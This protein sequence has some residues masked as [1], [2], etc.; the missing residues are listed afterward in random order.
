MSL[1]V[2]CIPMNP[3]FPAQILL[4][5]DPDL[6]FQLPPGYPCLDVPRATSVLHVLSQIWHFSPPCS[7]LLPLW[8]PFLG[9]KCL[10]FAVSSSESSPKL[11]SPAPHLPL[12]AHIQSITKSSWFLVSLFQP[13]HA[14]HCQICC[15]Y[16][17]KI[18]LTGVRPQVLWSSIQTGPARIFYSIVTRVY[19]P[20]F[21]VSSQ[22][23][24][25]VTDIKAPW[26]VTARRGQ[27]VL[28]LSGLERTVL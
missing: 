26:R 27:T 10:I 5:W 25:G 4:F 12:H 20:R 17:Y 21:F 15:L 28:W 13:F 9:Q 22:Q 24:F 8:S 18:L 3:T 23:K 2:S 7:N 19:A 14:C 16:G 6:K 11:S 1:D